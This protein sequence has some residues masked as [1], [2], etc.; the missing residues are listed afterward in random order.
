MDFDFSARSAQLQQD[1]LAFMDSH[2]YPA[3]EGSG[4]R[5]RA[6]QVG[7]AGQARTAGRR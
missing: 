7:T 4:F 6:G 3:E 5:T 1:L 2:V